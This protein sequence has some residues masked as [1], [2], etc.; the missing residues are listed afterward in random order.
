MGIMTTL[1]EDVN[2]IDDCLLES[3]NETDRHS[4]SA[5][6][7]TENLRKITKQYCENDDED[8]DLD[9]SSCNEQEL[10]ENVN[11]V[12]VV[13]T[14]RKDFLTLVE[15][16]NKLNDQ[17][18]V[19][20]CQQQKHSKALRKYG[21]IILSQN[22]RVSHMC[23]GDSSQNEL[24]RLQS[25]FDDKL[26]M[27]SSTLEDKFTK[28]LKSTDKINSDISK[29]NAARAFADGNITAKTPLVKQQVTTAYVTPVT[30]TRV[31]RRSGFMQ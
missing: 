11:I 8:E 4:C 7:I 16:T 21:Q 2:S 15:L 10:A 18:N 9:E 24:A 29:S 19:M 14:L 30:K 3:N 12:N 27:M 6:E 5:S 13:S 20:S 25:E 1:S 22:D 26:T 31:V 17:V 23:N 28:M